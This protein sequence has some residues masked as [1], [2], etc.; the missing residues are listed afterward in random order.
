LPSS[1]NNYLI[2]LTRLWIRPKQ[3]SKFFRRRINAIGV[4]C[5][6]AK[7]AWLKHRQPFSASIRHL[8]ASTVL[9][10]NHATFTHRLDAFVGISLSGLRL[11]LIPRHPKATD[12]FL[13][14]VGAFVF[15]QVLGN[16]PF[17]RLG[18]LCSHLLPATQ[19]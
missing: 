19:L 8:R 9:H 11:I 7:W 13:I 6:G 18:L 17:R 16:G 3:K 15:G 5:R 14:C 12:T 10:P 1:I 4:I 2:V